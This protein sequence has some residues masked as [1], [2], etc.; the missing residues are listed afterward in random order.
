MTVVEITKQRVIKAIKEEPLLR[1]GSWFAFSDNAPDD[2]DFKLLVGDKK[3]CTVCAVGAVLRDVLD[4]QSLAF[5]IDDAVD[6]CIDQGLPI[7][8]LSSYESIEDTLKALLIDK[9]YMNALSVLFETSWDKAME[10]NDYNDLSRHQIYRIK[11]KLIK[12]VQKNF[13]AKIQID[14]D[15]A[16]PAKDVK[17]VRK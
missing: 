5:D 13:P 8:D 6:G 2:F 11:Q 9:H 14:I 4:K 3:N 17:V 1:G 7:S 15:G 16:K 12:F 10:K